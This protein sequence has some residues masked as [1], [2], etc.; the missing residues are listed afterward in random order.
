M[1]KKQ[2]TEVQQT[3]SSIAL[4][5]NLLDKIACAEKHNKRGLEEGWLKERWAGKIRLS[6]LEQMKVYKSTSCTFDL[7]IDINHRLLEKEDIPA[8]KEL[9]LRE[10]ISD[11]DKRV[12]WDTIHS[13]MKHPSK[14]DAIIIEKVGSSTS[15]EYLPPFELLKAMKIGEG[16]YSYVPQ[17]EEFKALTTFMVRGL[18]AGNV[19]EGHWYRTVRHGRCRSGKVDTFDFNLSMNSQLYRVVLDGRDSGGDPYTP[20]SYNLVLTIEKKADEES[21]A[22]YTCEIPLE[23]SVIFRNLARILGAKLIIE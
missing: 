9:I 6:S 8:I 3:N 12:L 4:E 16:F 1:W 2:L 21:K 22:C 23:E 15:S 11:Y 18:E 19:S 7:D 14:G 10:D 20:Q 13:F 17:P 5:D